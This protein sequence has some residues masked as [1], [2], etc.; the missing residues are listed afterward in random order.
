[1]SVGGRESSRHHCIQFTIVYCMV[2]FQVYTAGA[3][4]W[5]QVKPCMIC[6]ELYCTVL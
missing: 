1:V 3:Q 5:C 6:T 2:L 4:C